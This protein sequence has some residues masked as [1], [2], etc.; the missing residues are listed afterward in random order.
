MRLQLTLL[1]GLTRA[2]HAEPLDDPGA[3][4]GLH[5]YIDDDHV[6][7][8]SPFAAVRTDVTPRIAIAADTTVDA[9]SAA[10]VDVITSASPQTVHEQRVELGLASSY[11]FGRATWWTA[12][13]RASHE[14]D[15]DAIRLRASA[16]TE[17]A[18]RNTTL[19]LDYVL[20][21]DDVSSMSDRSFHQDRTS[22]ELVLGAS[23]LLTRRSVVDVE[24]DLTTSDGYHASPYRVVRVEAA[25]MPLP[26]SLDE[27]TPTLRESAAITTRVRYAPMDRWTTS[28]A[29]RFYDDT[30]SVASHTLTAEV[31]RST[32]DRLIGLTLRGYSQG[33]AWFY[34]ERYT[35]ASRYR[36]HDR[37]LGAMRSLYGAVTLDAALASCHV[38]TSVG[39]LRLWFL[40]F[41]PQ[42]DRN[43]VLVYSSVT[44][45]W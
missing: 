9:V 5:V 7:V 39:L 42:S 18:Q 4:G 41:L 10:S 19:Q 44:R 43:A 20:G 26:M 12:G 24:L 21:Y 2:L 37:T 17:L 14:H 11:R 40:D 3:T 27:V 30:W 1:V 13:A 16:K 22:H 29:Y 28:A 31:L 25:G 38:V 8:V 6:T 45:S 36:T 34:A 32:A 33:D 15:Y 23:Q 35:A